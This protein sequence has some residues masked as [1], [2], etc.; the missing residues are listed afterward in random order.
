MRWEAHKGVLISNEMFT[1]HLHAA[2]PSVFRS[3]VTICN[4]NSGVTDFYI[5]V[6]SGVDYWSALKSRIDA[7]KL[8][9][10]VTHM[11]LLYGSGSEAYTRQMERA[12]E[13]HFAGKDQRQN[14]RA[15]RLA[16]F[17]APAAVLRNATG[18]GGGRP[19][20]SGN[21]FLYLALRRA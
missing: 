6:A 2:M 11:Y 16:G 9:W 3:I 21:Y 17:N 4:R 10:G 14:I 12:I 19:G 5:G 7:R 8:A 15:D 18:G 1:G 13:A 20:L